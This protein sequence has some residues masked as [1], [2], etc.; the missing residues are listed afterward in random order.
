MQIW[1]RRGIWILMGIVCW[2]NSAWFEWDKVGA[3]GFV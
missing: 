1:F 2:V 3:V